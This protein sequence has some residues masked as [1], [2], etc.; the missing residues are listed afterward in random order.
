MSNAALNQVY[1]L[2]NVADSKP[3]KASF[4]RAHAGP[5]KLGEGNLS[6]SEKPGFGNVEYETTVLGGPKLVGI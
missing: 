1:F 3:V 5:S 6:D 4:F 2:R